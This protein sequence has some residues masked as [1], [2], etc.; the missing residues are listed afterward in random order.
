[1]VKVW[2]TDA[3]HPNWWEIRPGVNYVRAWRCSQH[4]AVFLKTLTELDG[5]PAAWRD[6]LDLYGIATHVLADGT[7][8]AWIGESPQE[9]VVLAELRPDKINVEDWKGWPLAA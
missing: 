2:D 1:M 3:V 5:F 8:I 4:L 6:M 9:A 7:A